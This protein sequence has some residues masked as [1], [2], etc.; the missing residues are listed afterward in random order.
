[1]QDEV[2]KHTKKIFKTMSNKKYSMPEKFKEISIEILIIVFAVTLSIKLHD[3]S[4]HRHQQKEVKEFLTDLRE[5]LADDIETMN[6]IKAQLTATSEDKTYVMSFTE[7]KFDSIRS[8]KDSTTFKQEF[9]KKIPTSGI[10]RNNISGNYEGFKS[11]GKIGNIENKKIKKLMLQYYQ[12]LTP[13][14]S[15]AEKYYN[16][17]LS[18]TGNVIAELKGLGKKGKDIIFNPKFQFFFNVTLMQSISMKES[19]QDIINVAKEL[20]AE[21]AKELKG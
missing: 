13:C 20:D 12:Q 3:W 2:S 10:T 19:Y 11:S 5:D 21:I 16:A 8:T 14:L 6:D 9:E 15:D 18:N 1:M 4:E 17:N 7:Q